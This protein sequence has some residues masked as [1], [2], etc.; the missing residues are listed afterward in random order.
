VTTKD[1][2]K[3]VGADVAAVTPGWPADRAGLRPGDAIVAVGVHPVA[4]S[5]TL[6]GMLHYVAAGEAL[7]V[8]VTR[9][10]Q[11]VTLIVI[12]GG[13]AA[14]GVETEEVAGGFVG[15]FVRSVASGGA[16]Q[17][18]GIRPGD[19]I[20]SVDGQP[21]DGGSGLAR[22]LAGYHSGDAIAAVV[23]RDGMETL[24]APTLTFA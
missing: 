21:V 17:R 18:V 15:A 24:L 3:R 13:N 11:R 4:N 22:I 6:H 5:S 1:E 2:R 23:R 10:E 12:T 20:T 19:V 9:E 16:A 7:Q 8:T 14:L